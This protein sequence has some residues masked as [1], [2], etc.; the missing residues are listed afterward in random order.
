MSQHIET[1]LKLKFDIKG[2]CQQMLE[3]FNK[4][5]DINVDD[6]NIIFY[7]NIFGGLK[8][9]K[10]YP[11]VESND[12]DSKLFV[13]LKNVNIG[14]IVHVSYLPYSQKHLNY[15]DQK[16]CGIVFFIDIASDNALLYNDESDDI[17]HVTRTI[18]SISR[19]GCGFLGNKGYFHTICLKQ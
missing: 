8:N 3:K 13:S 7:E 12:T 11:I 6:D 10:K 4:K 18:Y 14:D 17:N 19:E 9:V 5:T 1:T 15:Y 16:I 2:E